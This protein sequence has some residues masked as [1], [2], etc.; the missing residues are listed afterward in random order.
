MYK[1]HNKTKKLNHLLDLISLC[2]PFFANK[3]EKTI[4]WK[5]KI[6]KIELLGPKPKN[7]DASYGLMMI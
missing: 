7:I 2:I 3:K 5:K 1:V 6:S 4:P